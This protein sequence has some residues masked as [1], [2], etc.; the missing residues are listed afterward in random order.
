MAGHHPTADHH[1]VTIRLLIADDEDLVRSGIRMIVEQQPDFEVAGE[2]TTGVEAVRQTK[3]LD[4]DVTLLDVRM[5]DLD[6]IQAAARISRDAPRTRILM[7]T[8][9][10]KDRYLYDGMKA[11]ASGFMLKSAPPDQLIG[12]IRVVAA[13]D[14]LLAP[15]LTRRLLEDF[16][17]RPP[18][19][20]PPSPRLL[21]LTEREVEILRLVAYGLTNQAIADALH[22]SIS[23]VKTHINRLFRKLDIGE[24]VQ[25][26][27]YAYETGLVHPGEHSDPR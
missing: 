15:A 19:G 18:P 24:R 25:A 2:A 7:L 10:D 26:V 5:P 23:T 9:F 17:R 1:V 27:I 6:G 12:A 22:V 16:T 8:T 20:P 3:A 4:P 11:G 13:G 14:A 21:G